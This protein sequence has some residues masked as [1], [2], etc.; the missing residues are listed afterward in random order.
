MLLCLELDL[1]VK[2]ELL[3]GGWLCKV[4]LVRVL[5]SEFDLLLFD[6]FINYL[7]MSSVI[8]FE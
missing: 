6:E 1:E 8:W 3:L 4:V 7:D 5:V 2:F